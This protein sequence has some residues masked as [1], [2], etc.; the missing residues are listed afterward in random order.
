VWL[1]GMRKIN[2]AGG[3]PFLSPKYLGEM[4]DFWKEVLRLES[5]SVVTNGSLVKASFLRQHAK[6]LD[7]LAVSCDSFDEATNIAIGRGSG[8]QVKNLYRFGNGVASI[9][10]CSRSTLWSTG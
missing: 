3:E 5:V 7:I 6:N 2:F 10:S 9:T 1:A 4:I 8:D